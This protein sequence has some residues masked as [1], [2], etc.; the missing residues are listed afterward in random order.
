MELWETMD[1]ATFAVLENVL[2]KHKNDVEYWHDSDG[3]YFGSERPPPTQ[4]RIPAL[5][6]E[7]ST[8]HI[9]TDDDAPVDLNYQLK[10]T[11]NVFVTV[12]LCGHAED[13][14]IQL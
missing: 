3:G 6:H 7:S 8:M 4:R 14:G 2:A 12:D 9:G 1:Q 5:V 13:Y 11:K 10:N